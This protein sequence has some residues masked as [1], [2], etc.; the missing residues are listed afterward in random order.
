MRRSIKR[1]QEDNLTFA[2]LPMPGLSMM[3]P[4]S[5]TEAPWSYN[6]LAR[7]ETYRWHLASVSNPSVQASNGIAL[8]TVACRE[9][10]VDADYVLVTGGLHV[11][12]QHAKVQNA[13]TCLRGN[14]RSALFTRDTR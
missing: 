1:E 6:R 4:A 12:G 9:T 13:L 2:F 5:T 10:L 8:P 14:L 3:S 7:R 11:E